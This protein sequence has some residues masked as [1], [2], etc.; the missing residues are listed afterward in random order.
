MST[1]GLHAA[2]VELEKAMTATAAAAA[3][4][5]ATA[6]E[7][8][9]DEAAAVAAALGLGPHLDSL[10][11]GVLPGGLML[12]GLSGGER[13]RLSIGLGARLTD[14]TIHVHAI[15]PPDYPSSPPDVRMM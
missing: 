10:I 11:G 12:Q 8:L 6:A 5:A 4:A 1:E 14:T 9:D 15:F 13:R 7:T 2:S 3:A